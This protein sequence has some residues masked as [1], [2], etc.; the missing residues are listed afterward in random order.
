MFL[1]KEIMNVCFHNQRYVIILVLHKCFFLFELV[2]QTSDVAH[3]PLVFIFGELNV[4]QSPYVV[5]LNKR[6]FLR[7]LIYSSE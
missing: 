1:K 2:F 7:E 6:W 3:G 5:V 4:V